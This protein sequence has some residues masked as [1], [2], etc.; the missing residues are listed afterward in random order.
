MPPS[1]GEPVGQ[2][3]VHPQEDGGPREDGEEEDRLAAENRPE[4]TEIPD[5]REPGPIDQEAARQAQYDEAGQ[6][7]DNS[8]HDASSRH[9]PL[10]RVFFMFTASDRS[11]LGRA[12]RTKDTADRPPVVSLGPNVSPG[13]PTPRCPSRHVILAVDPGFKELAASA[14]TGYRRGEMRPWRRRHQVVFQDPYPSLN[15]RLRIRDIIGE[16]LVNYGVSGGSE[17]TGRVAELALKVGLREDALDRYRYP[18]EFSGGQRQWAPP[19]CPTTKS[20]DLLGR[21]CRLA[22]TLSGSSGQRTTIVRG[23]IEKVIVDD[24]GLTIRVRGGAVLGRA[25]ASP[26][27]DIARD[28]SIEFKAAVAFLRRGDRGG[29]QT[30]GSPARRATV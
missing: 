26:A 23:L 7:D 24:H 4:D 14:S 10:P 30:S 1:P 15:P 19:A 12:P 17:L 22:A 5:G 18:H 3:S 21:A 13:Y 6:D 20:A 9:I 27:P 25:V 28:A 16:P 11:R 2:V 29:R 8:D